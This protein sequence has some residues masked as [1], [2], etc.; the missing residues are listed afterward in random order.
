VARPSLRELSPLGSGDDHIHLPA[1]ALKT[2]QPLA[3]IKNR[4]VRAVSS[5]HLGGVRLDL[6][7]AR[8]AGCVLLE[9]KAA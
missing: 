6:M 5:S 4:R 1:A 2:H 3:P 7:A 9:P 8:N